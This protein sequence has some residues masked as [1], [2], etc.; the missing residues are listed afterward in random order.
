VSCPLDNGIHG[1]I[2]GQAVVNVTL[3]VTVTGVNDII[4]YSQRRRG[5]AF[6][7]TIPQYVESESRLFGNADLAVL[8][9]RSVS[10]NNCHV[11]R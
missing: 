7:V 6:M 4:D 2:D 10:G 5:S 11:T 9:Y 3:D 8:R 1:L